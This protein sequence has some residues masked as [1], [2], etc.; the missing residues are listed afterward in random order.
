MRANLVRGA[1]AIGL[2]AAAVLLTT[3]SAVADP[4]GTGSAY[5]AEAQVSLLPGVLGQ[6]GLTVATGQ[7]APSST[8]GPTSAS[9]VDATLKG[10]VSAKAITS[11]ANHDQAT[12][13]VTATASVVDASLPVLAGVV[14]AVPSASVITSRCHATA[15]GITGSS[16]LA[17]L[18]LGKLGTVS[19]AT[20][21]LDLGVPGVVRVVANE[22]I[23][24]ADGSLT[25]NALH[26]TLLGGTLTGA[27]GSGDIVLASSTCGQATPVTTTTSTTTTPPA[28]APTSAAPAPGGN[29]VSVVPAGAP[30]TGDGSLAVVTVP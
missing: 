24:H 10:L 19:A 11:S 15:D 3:T 23:H 21:N 12:G 9:A 6:S 29:E 1:G 28:P 4:A 2:A 13:D 16:D 22:Q 30:E 14:G 17:N 20:P 8:A 27:L 25:V 5:G 7:L 18:N 26:I